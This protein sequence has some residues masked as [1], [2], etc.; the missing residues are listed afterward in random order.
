MSLSLK[1]MNVVTVFTEDL[2]GTRSFYEEVLGLR[3]LGENENEHG[4]SV[5]FEL[6]NVMINLAHVS[7]GA[8]FGA[9]GLVAGRGAGVRVVLPA[10]VD[11]VDTA[12]AELARLGVPLVDGP[13]DR[14]WGIR[15]ASFSD[16][17]GHIWEIAADLD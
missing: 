16:P 2:A 13:V 17:A 3:V 8:D 1:S 12:C 14:P 9:P 10:A 5:V 4:P 15:T 11:D 7:A 6:G